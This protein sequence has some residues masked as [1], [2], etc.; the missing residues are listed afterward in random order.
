LDKHEAILLIGP[1]GSGKTPLGDLFEDRG[2]WGRPCAHFDFGRELRRIGRDGDPLFDP[3]EIAFIRRV[4]DEGLLLENEHFHVAWKILTA[5]IAGRCSGHNGLIVLNGLPRHVGQAGD[6]DCMVDVGAVVHLNCTPEAVL[7]RIRTN[8]GGDRTR[9]ADDALA[10]VRKRLADFDERTRPVLEHYRALGAS[11]VE[12][13][14]A[15]DA[16]SEDIMTSLED[17]NAE[18]R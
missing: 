15:P 9:R 17:R 3:D 14:V 10:A 5:F 4:L 2:L 13:D 1:T 7:E 16:T 18:H 11:V 8:A 12:I 6:V